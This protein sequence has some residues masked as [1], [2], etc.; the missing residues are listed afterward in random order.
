MYRARRTLLIQFENDSIDESEEIET[1]LKEAYTIMRMKRP[2]VEM[3]V[4][5][6]QLGGTHITPLTQNVIIEPP[7]FELEGQS[8]PDPLSSVRQ[9]LRNNFLQTIDEVKLE[10]VD[11]LAKQ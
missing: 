9:E 10:I 6:K 11:W 5:L 8:I 7:L 2:L 4:E 1:V 3:E